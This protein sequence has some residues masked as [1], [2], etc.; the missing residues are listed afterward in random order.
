MVDRDLDRGGAVRKVVPRSVG[1]ISGAAVALSAVIL[2][3]AFAAPAAADPVPGIQVATASAL[4]PAG[5][6]AGTTVVASCPSGTSLIGGGVWTGK[7]DPGDPAV[8]TNGLRVKGTYPSDASGAPLTDGTATPDFWSA[9]GNFG[10]R[11]EPGDQVTSFALCAAKK[12]QHRVVS[13]ASVNA[14]TAAHQTAMV[15][16]TCPAG[17]TIVGGGALGTPV[18]SPAFKPIGSYPS[19]AEGNMLPDGA[20]N[21]ASWTAVGGNGGSGDPTAITTAFAVCA[22][23][24][25]V[26]S[27]ITRVDAAG[28]RSGNSFAVIT[29][30]CA[31]TRLLGGGVNFDNPAGPLEGGEHLRGSYPS[32]A[33]GDPVAD[34]TRD[35]AAWSAVVST[36]SEP[37][38]NLTVH[39]FA[40]CAA[41]RAA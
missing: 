13:V 34:G 29:A 9:A 8:P 14:P 21:P 15:T 1:S 30:S 10:G 22:K 27:T 40:I 17:T 12:N 23:P 24:Q 4:I 18:G 25:G 38:P 20:V 28:P 19:D 7:A 2:V 32:D 31:G 36:G 5:S 33:A 26:L 11:S 37:S 6:A 35:P 41:N 16:A 3:G 39:V